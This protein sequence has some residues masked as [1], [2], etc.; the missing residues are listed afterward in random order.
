MFD[1][2]L[3]IFIIQTIVRSIGS[4]GDK[5]VCFEPYHELYPSQ[6]AIFYL[7]PTFVTLHASVD[8]GT[9][10]YDYN[11]LKDA[12]SDSKTKALILNT[13]HNP[14]GKVFSHYELSQIVEL[15]VEHNVYI[16]T[17][18]IYE[19]M[20]YPDANNN[21][22]EHILI[23]K[24]FPE[25][26]DLTLVC[27]S[28]GKSASATGWRLGWCLTPPHLTDA[29]RGIHDQLAVMSPHPMQFASL[30][31]FTLPVPYFKEELR[32]RYQHR[33]ELLASA[34]AKVGFGVVNPEGA[35]YLFVNYRG[36]KQ[37]KNMAPMDAAMYLINEVGVA[38]VPGDNFYS[39]SKDGNDYL[40]FACCRSLSD[41]ETAILRLR[42]NLS[43]SM[44]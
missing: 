19:W 28:M 33:V 44:K 3:T 5:V 22:R 37:L 11:E 40:R 7:E 4:P 17:D 6:C 23:P 43:P 20:T 29:F 26:T 34:L 25:V 35:Y 27:N 36:V 15:C 13:P 39:K 10:D 14:T 16:I 2:F 1:I 38:C 30:A 32:V 31:Y 9:W 42:D 18:E 24:A 8:D 21:H 41:I 12:I